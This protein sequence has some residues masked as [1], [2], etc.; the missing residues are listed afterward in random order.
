MGPIHLLWTYIVY[1]VG[2]VGPIHLLRTYI[3]LVGWGLYTYCVVL[4]G[5]GLYT[6]S[7]RILPIH[8]LRTYIVYC[9]GRV[10]PC[11]LLLLARLPLIGLSVVIE[12]VLCLDSTYTL[13]Q[14]KV[15]KSH[16]SRLV[17]A[18][19]PGPSLR[20]HGIIACNDL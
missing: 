13:C 9:V 19:F 10:G 17:L 8:L 2:R 16:E 5:W 7:G 20:A 12:S 4:V 1:C 3:V 18:S 14:T 11:T 6:Y 15:T